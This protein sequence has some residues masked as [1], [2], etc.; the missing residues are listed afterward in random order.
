MFKI[1]YIAIVF[2]DYSS[3]YLI[4][5]LW[6]KLFK[7]TW[8]RYDTMNLDEVMKSKTCLN[9]PGKRNAENIFET[10]LPFS[11]ASSTHEDSLNG[12]IYIFSIE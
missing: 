2:L 1:F 6:L 10:S 7:S 3:N 9:Q 8:N 11:C 5:D 12:K 4:S